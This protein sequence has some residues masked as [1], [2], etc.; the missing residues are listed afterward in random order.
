MTTEEIN[1]YDDLCKTGSVSNCCGAEMYG[2]SDICPDCGEH[3][4]PEEEENEG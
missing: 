3:C 1:G 2:D 4:E